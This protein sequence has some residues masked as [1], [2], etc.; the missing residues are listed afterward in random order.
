MLEGNREP[1]NVLE[2]DYD[3]LCRLPWEVTIQNPSEA[4]LFPERRPQFLFTSQQL[5]ESPDLNSLASK[6]DVS[7]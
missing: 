4:S 7:L 1:L 2:H 6:I 5:Q 3:L